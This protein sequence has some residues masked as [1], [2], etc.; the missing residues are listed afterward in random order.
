MLAT[1]GGSEETQKLGTGECAFATFPVRQKGV[2]AAP[3]QALLVA[4][5][6]REAE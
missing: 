1:A 6:L 3:S 4:Q 2:L 5:S